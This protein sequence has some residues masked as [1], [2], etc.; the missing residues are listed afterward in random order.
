MR[1]KGARPDLNERGEGNTLPRLNLNYS[2]H[3]SKRGLG[4]L[5]GEETRGALLHSVLAAS[6]D[7]VPLGILH[8]K[9]WARQGRKTKQRRRSIEE[10]ESVRWLESAQRSEELLSEK[11]RVITVADREAD[12]YELLSR[13]RPANSDYLIRSHHDRRVK[14]DGA[15]WSRSLYGLLEETLSGGHFS[16]S[17]KRNPRRA[18]SDVFLRA[19]WLDIWLQPPEDHQGKEG[20][21][22]VRVRVLNVSEVFREPSGDGPPIDWTLITTLPI[23]SLKEAQQLLLWYSYRWL[24]E[25]Y[26]FVLKSG[27]RVEALQLETFDRLERAVATYA[28]VG[29]R[30]MWVAYLSRPLNDERSDIGAERVFEEEE[31]RALCQY[32]GEP[33][34]S[35]GCEEKIPGLRECVVWIARLGG[36]LG[37]KCDGEPGLKTIWRGLRRLRDLVALRGSP[38]GSVAIQAA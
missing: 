24:I 5:R 17:L 16:L 10:K 12:I 9:M 26:H 35:E 30:L 34:E 7:G 15:R 28:I 8:Q 36:Y 33:I 13:E 20:L 21:A 23:G 14:K 38:P 18:A 22:P 11:T 37:R 31:W 32:Y 25:R 19:K 2:G 4:Y 3:R 6:A 1:R 27:C 29:W